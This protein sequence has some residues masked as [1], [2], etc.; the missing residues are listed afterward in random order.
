MEYSMREF[1]KHTKRPSKIRAMH[2]V[3]KV[4]GKPNLELRR[5]QS[6][7]PRVRGE[8]VDKSITF[9]FTI[10]MT[11]VSLSKNSMYRS[12]IATSN[13]WSFC[14]KYRKVSNLRL[15]Y[16]TRISSHHAASSCISSC[17]TISIS[18]ESINC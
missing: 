16:A 10:R 8:L 17:K 18:A 5:I 7:N 12:A 14:L 6:Q 3:A 2:N 1:K 13:T 11:M 9:V 4:A 15:Q